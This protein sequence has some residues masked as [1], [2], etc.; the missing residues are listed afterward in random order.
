M[1]GWANIS[2][3]RHSGQ[4]AGNLQFLF[5]KQAV[6]G[7]RRRSHNDLTELFNVEVLAAV[8]WVIIPCRVVAEYSKPTLNRLLLIQIDI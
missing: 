8:F 3:S 4:V 6:R 1:I 5:I 7:N 2:A